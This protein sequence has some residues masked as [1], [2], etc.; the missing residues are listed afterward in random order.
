MLSKTLMLDTD[1]YWIETNERHQVVTP[2]PFRALLCASESRLGKLYFP[3]VIWFPV[4]FCQAGTL[5]AEQSMLLP[6]C[7][8][9]PA[10]SARQAVLKASRWGLFG[11][12]IFSPVL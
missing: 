5:E 7:R 11:L 2:L 4:R 10:Q 1:Y 6:V 9:V 8:A 3:F 12:S